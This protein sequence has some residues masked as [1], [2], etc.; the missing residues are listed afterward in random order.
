MQIFKNINIIFG[1]K[2]K[3][4]KYKIFFLQIIL[5]LLE[6]LGIALLLPVLHFLTGVEI[7]S[8][9]VQTFEEIFQFQERDLNI[10]SILIII[11]A[12]F[13]AKINNSVH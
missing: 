5:V 1:Q 12:I 2:F 10:L 6:T 8:K 7:N 4:V 3:K 11:L 9:F 13:F